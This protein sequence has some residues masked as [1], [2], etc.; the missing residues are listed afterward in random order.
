M[1]PTRRLVS[2][3]LGCKTCYLEFQLFFLK[4]NNSFVFKIKTL[5]LRIV[6]YFNL[7]PTRS[8]RFWKHLYKGLTF[9]ASK[10]EY[11]KDEAEEASRLSVFALWLFET[12]VQILELLGIGEL[13]ETVNDF[14]KYNSRPLTP[15]EIKLAKSVYGETIDYQFIRLDERA[16]IGPRFYRFCYVSFNLVNSWGSMHPS[17]FIHELMHVWQY[18]QYGA[19]YM[20]RALIAQH[21]YCGYDYGGIKALKARRKKGEGLTD[22]NLEQQGDIIAD[23]F[24]LKSGYQTQWGNANLEDLVVYQSYINELKGSSKIPQA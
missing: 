23:Y 6:S 12:F 14:L 13:Y 3:R 11:W 21:T 5:Y 24:L 2:L 20:I 1:L 10:K 15:N 4:H 18:Q 22:F 16:H 8:I 9:N 7:I 17:I 19:I